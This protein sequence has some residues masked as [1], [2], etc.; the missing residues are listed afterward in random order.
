MKRFVL[1]AVLLLTSCAAPPVTLY[2]L[3][4]PAPTGA[5]LPLGAQPAVIAVE[6]VSLPDYLD[7]RDI[8]VGAGAVVERSRSGR[9]ASR[10][11]LGVTDLLTA[12]LAEKRP[13]AVVTARPQTGTPAYRLLI[14]IGRFDVTAEGA[15]TL[16]AGWQI[17]PGN[18]SAAAVRDRIRIGIAGPA[19][20][21][22]D[23]VVL[24]TAAVIQLAAA[25]DIV[26]LP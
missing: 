13:D 26:H 4:A 1:P 5:A 12:R 15:V 18:A 7:T 8:V 17:V 14:D 11:S 16:E 19:G 22:R 21:D 20:T 10:L 3:I 23:V 2:T 25:I 24:M 6:R 9:W